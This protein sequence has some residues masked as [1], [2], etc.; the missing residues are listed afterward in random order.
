MTRKHHSRK[1]GISLT[2]A[3]LAATIFL[4]VLMG[5]LFRTA[6]VGAQYNS[7]GL[8]D[9]QCRYAAYGAIERAF[10][11]LERNPDWRD[12]WPNQEPM[13]QNPDITYKLKVKTAV[14]FATL[15]PDEIYLFSQG[16]YKGESGKALA[17]MGGTAFRPGGSFT[18]SAF[19]DSSL[20]LM[21]GSTSDGFDSRIGDHWYNPSETDAAKL[22]LVATSGHIGGNDSITLDASSVD[23]DVILPQPTSF[24]LDGSTQ[25]TRGNVD[26]SGGGS[27]SGALQEPNKPRDLPELTAPFDDSLATTVIDATNFISLPGDTDSTPLLAPGAYASVSV[28]SGKTVRLYPGKYY[29]KDLLSLDNATL[30]VAGAGDVQ[31]FCGQQMTV[32]AGSTVNH[33][34]VDPN[35]LNKKPRN[36][37]I[38]FTG[39]NAQLNINDSWVSCAAIGKD[40]QANLSGSDFFGSINAAE[41]MANSS[42]LHY[43]K[44][45]GNLKVSGFARWQL[46]GLTN[47]PPGTNL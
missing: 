10:G 27:Y 12:G 36:L 38:L 19:G 3:I 16:F 22:T 32:L 4:G 45:L 2:I 9:R 26:L 7:D 28:P 31:I 33:S 5:V 44:D 14:P 25:G 47:L 21:G 13:P 17:A 11:E 18:E 37:Q 46:R 8:R 6:R 24:E 34:T 1:R 35:N 29:F 15:G 42:K 23:G 30:Q 41:V 40:L 43:D 20:A 39:E